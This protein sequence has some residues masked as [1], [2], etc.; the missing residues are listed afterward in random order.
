MSNKI[1]LTALATATATATTVPPTTVT[2]T[3]ATATAATV[4]TSFWQDDHDDPTRGQAKH[5][6]Q[7]K[8]RTLL[9]CLATTDQYALHMRCAVNQYNLALA[10]PTATVANP[11]PTATATAAMMA[12]PA[13]N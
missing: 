6:A 10:N 3:S 12:M 2:A 5:K 1:R 7:G 11:T 4:G 8:M 9:R 13:A